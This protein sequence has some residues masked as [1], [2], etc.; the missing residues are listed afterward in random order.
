MQMRGPKSFDYFRLSAY[1]SRDLAHYIMFSFAL[2][3]T[4]KWWTDLDESFRV[5]SIWAWEGA[6]WFSE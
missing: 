6:C 4:Q 5:D 3:I 1:G 2:K